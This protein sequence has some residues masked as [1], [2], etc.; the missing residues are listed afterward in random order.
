M[1]NL[2]LSLI[3]N[4][5]QGRAD[6]HVSVRRYSPGRLVL[7]GSAN[8]GL[9]YIQHG[10]MELLITTPEGNERCMRILSESDL[11]GLECLYGTGLEPGY[12]VRAITYSSVV[13]IDLELVD[14]WLAT[15]PEFRRHLATR[16]AA[17]V[18]R[19]EQ[20]REK[21]LAFSVAERLVCYLRCGESC[22]NL[23]PTPPEPV[24]PLP[25]AILARRIG[26]SPAYLSRAVRKLIQQGVVQR[27]NHLPRIDCLENFSPCPC[28]AVPEG[29]DGLY[30]LI[31]SA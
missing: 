25:M 6:R 22:A 17:D 1:R 12:Q 9:F 26:C 2:L 3:A 27:I 16:I 14:H 11:F 23:L 31:R 24:A 5:E 8:P 19:L 30:G 15:Q 7:E 21:T 4:T 13:R 18:L 28:S 10:R 29:S 20:E